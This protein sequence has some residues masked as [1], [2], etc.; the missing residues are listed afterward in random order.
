MIVFLIVNRGI[1]MQRLKGWRL[2]LVIAIGFILGLI[3]GSVL[4]QA[5][6]ATRKEASTWLKLLGDIFVR[7]IRVVIPPLI[8]FTIAAAVASIADL[9]KLG[10]I[11]VLMLILYVATSTLA[12]TWGVLAGAIFTPGSGIAETTARIQTTEPPYRY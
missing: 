3:V 2:L 9:K 6:E 4:L 11:L 8:F 10:A 1:D 5:P 12:A 7:L